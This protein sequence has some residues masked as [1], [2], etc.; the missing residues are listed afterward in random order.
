MKKFKKRLSLLATIMM[1]I[2][3]IN[4]GALNSNANENTQV[5]SQSNVATT[6]DTSI[7]ITTTTPESLKLGYNNTKKGDAII[8]G[9][10]IQ[11]D[12]SNVIYSLPDDTED[13]QFFEINEKNVVCKN[14]LNKLDYTIKVRATVGT[15]HNDKVFNISLGKGVIVLNFI[16]DNK[17]GNAIDIN[18][19]NHKNIVTTTDP[20]LSTYFE[21]DVNSNDKI[22][23]IQ[24]KSDS[25]YKIF[26]TDESV[27]D[28]FVKIKLKND[29]N[30]SLYNLILE[31]YITGDGD[32]KPTP[33][34]H[35]FYILDM[36]KFD[37]LKV[38]EIKI[39]NCS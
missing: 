29:D 20:M 16:R 38:K 11:G 33:D 19:L 12:N 27:S 23:N 25:E 28:G 36:K 18:I 26:F 14:D 13:N 6:T 37:I 7:V 10:N 9:L 1:V 8:S 35:G 22:V 17:S 4:T 24:K 32:K 3:T 15:K 21:T 2:T 39:L 30:K 5:S 34:A 31:D